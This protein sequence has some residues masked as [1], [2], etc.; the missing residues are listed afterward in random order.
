MN[1]RD[2]WKTLKTVLPNKNNSHDVPS[3]M[4][5]N[6]F[7]EFFT[8]IGENVTKSIPSLMPVNQSNPDQQGF[9]TPL[10]FFIFYKYLPA[11]CTRKS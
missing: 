10:K 2:L 5:A 9:K 3:E 11:Q 8:T 4:K 1:P 6:S 7:N